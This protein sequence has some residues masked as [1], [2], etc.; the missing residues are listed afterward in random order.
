MFS[1]EQ[2]YEEKKI[3]RAMT[4]LLLLGRGNHFQGSLLRIYNTS[5]PDV[6]I[7]KTNKFTIAKEKTLFL[8]QLLYSP[9][10]RSLSRRVINESVTVYIYEEEKKNS[11]YS[12]T[13][14]TNS[15]PPPLIFGF[16]SAEMTSLRAEKKNFNALDFEDH[17]S[18]PPLKNSIGR[19]RGSR[20]IFIYFHA[21]DFY[22]STSSLRAHQSADR[23]E[24][25]V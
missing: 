13:P 14:Q 18:Y 7:A 8:L 15:H 24:A 6:Y 17:L 23:G 25:V 10:A 12:T 19:E 3:V 20:C 22:L 21:S 16:Y 5:E 1:V 4:V 2:I 11:A 9:L